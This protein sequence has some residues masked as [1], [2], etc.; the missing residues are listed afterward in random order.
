MDEPDAASMKVLYDEYG[1]AL[2]RY[3]M[4]LTGDRARAEDV[5]REPLL[6]AW[7]HPEVA[8]DSE[9]PVRAWLLPRVRQRAQRRAGVARATGPRRRRI[10]R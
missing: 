3:A 8:D 5:V 7:Q 10:D 9:R 1:A 6:L 4:R 2:W